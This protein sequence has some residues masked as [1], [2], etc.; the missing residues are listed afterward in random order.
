MAGAIEPPS[1]SFTSQKLDLQHRMCADRRVTDGQFRMFVRVLRAMN[2]QT[3]IAVLGDEAIM[4]EVPSCGS[5]STCKANRR[6]LEALGYW[7]VT[8]G[9]GSRT[10]EYKIDLKAGMALIEGLDDL[11][12][13]RIQRRRR[14][15]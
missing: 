3:E 5:P 12:V 2:A 15:T 9:S 4:A 1:K 13:Q 6:H 8:P 10:T 14:K 7:R 11:R